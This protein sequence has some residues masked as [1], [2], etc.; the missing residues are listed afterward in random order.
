M[1]SAT[2]DKRHMSRFLRLLALYFFLPPFAAAQEERAGITYYAAAYFQA[3]QPSTA[4]DMLT[5]LP[6]FRLQEGDASIRGFS[7]AVG[8]VLIDGA[9]PTSKEENE[10]SLLARIPAAAVDHIALIRAGAAGFDLHGYALIANVVRKKSVSLRGRV[11]ME[12]AF[13][14][15]GLSAPRAALHLTRQTDNDT[16]DLS[17]SYGREWNGNHG[18][19][20]RNRFAPD[21]TVLRLA[22]YDQPEL[23]NFAE[24]TAQYRRGILGGRLDLSAVVKQEV[25]YSDIAERITFPAPQSSSGHERT[26]TRGFEAQLQYEHPLAD[27]GRWQIFAIHRINEKNSLSQSTDSSG[28]ELSLGNRSTGESVLRGELR[29]DHRALTMEAGAEGAFNLMRSANSLQINGAPVILPASNVRAQERRAEFFATGTWRARPDLTVE[30]S[31]RYEISTIGQSGENMLTRRLSF[32]KPRLLLSWDVAPSQSFRFLAE[33]RVGQLDFDGFVSSASLLN[34]NVSAGNQNLLPDR[35][36]RLELTWEHRFWDRASLTLSARRDSIAG[37]LDHLPVILNGELFDATGNIGSGRRDEITASLILPLDHLRL[38]GV[39]LKF[40]GTARHSKTRDPV[41]GAL[42]R[43]SGSEPL[44][45]T[46]S[47]TH[48]LPASNLRWGLSFGLATQETDYRIDEIDSRHHVSHLNTFVEY[49]PSAAWTLRLFC[50][51]LAQSAFVRDR[52]L[53]DGLRGMVPP[54]YEERRS[55]NNGA[56]LGL[57]IQASFGG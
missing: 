25:E 46:V 24:G 19:G 11:E 44:E 21:G 55:L 31:G 42:R 14:R 56:L 20:S 15:Y 18:F 4:L 2:G 16:L 43:F 29:V 47:F 52:T 27:I 30:V 32:F 40:D 23:K 57:N 9:L 34:N 22:D 6:G 35:T 12:Y 50:Q 41:T 26:L 7:G 45:G 1:K 36:T 38:A 48:D 39:T 28:T 10:Q 3:S 51:D 17:A 5:L 37:L 13:N 54:S 33:R 49:K 8:N 53:Y